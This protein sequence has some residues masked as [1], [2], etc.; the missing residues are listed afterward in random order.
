[1]A[2]QDAD[3]LVAHDLGHLLP[4]RERREHFLA[5]GLLL[6]VLD[7][8]FDHLEVDVGLQQSDADLLQSH[9]HIL[10]RQL[11]FS[12]QGFEDALEFFG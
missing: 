5:H 4:R 3:H 11:A 7:K 1:M 8:L 2:P 10:G 6:H 12:T 9:V